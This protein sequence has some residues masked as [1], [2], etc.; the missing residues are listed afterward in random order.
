ML[1][2]LSARNAVAKRSGGREQKLW[3]DC[4]LHPASLGCQ[5][6]PERNVCGGLPIAA[7]MFSCLDHCCRHPESCDTVCRNNPDYADRLRE[8]GGFDL[9]NIPRANPLPPPYLPKLI[10]LLYHGAQRE[11]PFRTEAVCLPLY[12]MLKRR[13]GDTQFETR[14][15]LNNAFQVSSE[16]TIILTGTPN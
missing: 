13:T 10:P 11:K 15:A 8:I 2:S 9:K 12:A 14:A 5:R 16:T 7:P 3:H 1:T 6:C 4:T